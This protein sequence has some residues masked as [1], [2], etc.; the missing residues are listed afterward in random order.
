MTSST[1]Q[2]EGLRVRLLD[3][4]AG[5][6]PDVGLVGMI[7]FVAARLGPG[8]SNKDPLMG[9]VSLRVCLHIMGWLIL[10]GSLETL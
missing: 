4:A 8:Y 2:G 1:D 7:V 6:S 3:G 5:D 10:L 9:G